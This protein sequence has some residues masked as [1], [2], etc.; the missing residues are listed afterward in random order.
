[1]APVSKI[2]EGW[3]SI[4][5]PLLSADRLSHAEWRNLC[6]WIL[7]PNRSVSILP[8]ALQETRSSTQSALC[9][10]C[11]AWLMNR[12]GQDASK[13]I[14]GSLNHQGIIVNAPVSPDQWFGPFVNEWERVPVRKRREAGDIAAVEIGAQ[15]EDG[16]TDVERFL[17][18]VAGLYAH[19][20]IVGRAAFEEEIVSLLAKL[21]PAKS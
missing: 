11:E 15:V 8:T 19:N 13:D 17:K 12:D 6:Q 4:P 16:K 20:G 14:D 1:M 9:I 10:L 7:D 18:R 2:P 21:K 5:R 3:L